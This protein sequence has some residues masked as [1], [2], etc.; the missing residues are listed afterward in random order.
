MTE[1]FLFLQAEDTST[2]KKVPIPDPTSTT[3]PFFVLN[4]S[5]EPKL[6]SPTHSV[7]AFSYLFLEILNLVQRN[8]FRSFLDAALGN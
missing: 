7:D 6:I 5:K 1:T 3:K 8:S 2:G 4:S